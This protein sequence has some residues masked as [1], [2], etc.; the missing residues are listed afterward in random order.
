VIENFPPAKKLGGANI[1]PFAQE[2]A[3]PASNPMDILLAHDRW[4]TGQIL[5]E[6]AKLTPE[7]FHQRFEMGPGSLHDTIN[8]MLAAMRVWNDLL[9]GH[10]QRPRLEGTKR[11]IPELTKLLDELTAELA[12]L[13][14][15]HPLD[16]TV[17]RLRDGKTYTFTRGAVITHVATHGMHHRAQS[18]NML[19]HLGVNPLP[20]SSVSEWT[21]LADGK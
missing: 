14:R 5:A 11:T 13:A 3:M 12:A 15:A 6:C 18:L 2:R 1:F 10:E 4:A 19:R 8:H 21:W 7:Q 16:S 17:T 20:P 9:A